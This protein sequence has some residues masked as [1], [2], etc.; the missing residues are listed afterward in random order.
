MLT[1]GLPAFAA[2]IVVAVTLFQFPGQLESAVSQEPEPATSTPFLPL[3]PCSPVH[4]VPAPA[5][6]SREPPRNLATR[7][8]ETIDGRTVT[9][10]LSDP[11]L[12]ETAI[13]GMGRYVSLTDG[14]GLWSLTNP[15]Q[16]A[17]TSQWAWEA[18]E[19]MP[20][21]DESIRLSLHRS[22]VGAR[23]IHAHLRTERP[24][25]LQVSTGGRKVVVKVE[26]GESVVPGL[27]TPSEIASDALHI[28]LSTAQALPE[29]AGSRLLGLW[30]VPR[31]GHPRTGVATSPRPCE[32]TGVVVEP[33]RTLFASGVGEAD[34]LLRIVASG[35]DPSL[36]EVALFTSG[37]GRKILA[38]PA[39]GMV[40]ATVNGRAEESWP[41]DL[42]RQRPVQV[43][44]SL[45]AG[46]ED[47]VCLKRLDLL[48]VPAQAAFGEVEVSAA[49]GVIVILLDTLRYDA[50]GSFDPR[51]PVVSPRL[52]EL[53][54]GSV[55]FTNATAH[56]NY[57]KP[58]IA[59]ILTGEYPATTGSLSHGGALRDEIPMVTEILEKAG[60]RTAGLFSNRFLAEEFNFMRGWN[61]REHVNSYTASLDGQVTADAWVDFIE[62]YEPDG[63][64]FL[65]IH[66][67]DPHAP[68]VPRSAS[69]EIKYLGHRLLGGRFDPRSTAQFISSL[70]KGSVWAPD[71]DELKDL[72]GLY[73]A[74]VA[75]M[76]TTVGQVLGAL[77]KAGLMD[78]TMLIVVS[79][80]GE[81]F[82]EHGYLGHGT[83]I[84]AELTHVPLMIRVPGAAVTGE[85]G[86][87]VGHIDLT[88]TI[89]DA[90]DVE[91]PAHL[92]GTS[93]ID[94]VL[95]ASIPG[96]PRAYLM[97]HWNGVW[98]LR[99]GEWLVVANPRSTSLSRIQ[100]ARIFNQDSSRQAVLWLYLRQRLA[101][102]AVASPVDDTSPEHGVELEEETR[103]ELEALG[104]IIE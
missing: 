21:T 73:R 25:D 89:L 54:A 66:L 22:L 7:P 69:L 38:S 92:S 18:G 96:E 83:N 2:G 57:T 63:P 95:A 4:A 20:V 37:K 14:S 61:R 33:G 30:I 47:G 55:R 103:E 19:G 8:T 39:P 24:F 51:S 36:L 40:L 46:A 77:E 23:C 34:D 16:L 100:G 86:E 13:E 32:K 29:D 101:L 75:G 42:A 9:S 90:L 67:M 49:R 45:P 58:S 31:N 43:S 12:I 91:V 56:A 93:L 87:L 82:M 41:V 84:Q 3:S 48:H 27:C 64:F 53:A 81:E 5:E 10:L 6:E 80:H 68:Y 17:Q 99:L 11:R 15:A 79:D 88:P 94:R 28:S 104:Y 97:Q 71:E 76:D 52:D 1:I 72:V 85:Y 62:G 59:S 78:D 60:V 74:D 70:R 65:Y 26:A 98:G 35:G 50:L 44:V 102:A